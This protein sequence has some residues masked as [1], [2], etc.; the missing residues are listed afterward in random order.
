MVSLFNR[1]NQDVD[2]NKPEE[3]S[4]LIIENG[5][6]IYILV[7]LFLDNKKTSDEED[8]EIKELF[9]EFAK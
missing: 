2:P 4:E 3:Y 7:N 6:N 9:D 8:L 5:F 1:A